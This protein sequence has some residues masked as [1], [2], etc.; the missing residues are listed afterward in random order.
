M[1]LYNKSEAVYILQSPLVGCAG[2]HLWNRVYNNTH[3]TNRGAGKAVI[4]QT[5]TS[6]AQHGLSSA[7]LS[8]ARNN[9]SS[10]PGSAISYLPLSACR[11]ITVSHQLRQFHYSSGCSLWIRRGSHFPPLPYHFLESLPTRISGHVLLPRSRDI[12]SEPHHGYEFA[13]FVSPRTAL[14]HPIVSQTSSN[15]NNKI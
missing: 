2:S 8:A 3:T 13:E 14:R 11:P 6:H 15:S 12:W 10:E 5:T 1:T 7:E 9:E 4:T